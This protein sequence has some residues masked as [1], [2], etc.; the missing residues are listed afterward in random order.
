MLFCLSPLSWAILIAWRPGSFRVVPFLLSNS[1]R[2]LLS[3]DLENR[4]RYFFFPCFACN[5]F[6]HSHFDTSLY[7]LIFTI[8]NLPYNHYVIVYLTILLYDL[9]HISKPRNALLHITSFTQ[10]DLL[11]VFVFVLWQFLSKRSLF[12]LLLDSAIGCSVQ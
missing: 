8:Y 10:T 6:K 3:S 11:F 4:L 9:V 7:L 12:S 5:S 1:L 2:L